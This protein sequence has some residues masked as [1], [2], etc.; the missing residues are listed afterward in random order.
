MSDSTPRDPAAVAWRNPVPPPADARAEAEP[1][2]LGFDGANSMVYIPAAS[3]AQAAM[4]QALAWAERASVWSL[5]GCVNSDIWQEWKA[6][7]RSL[8]PY[9]DH[10]PVPLPIDGHAYRRRTRARTRARARRSRSRRARA[11][12]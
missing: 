9:D 12:R 4:R 1:V 7:V 10:H 2:V 6:F 11:G 3:S 5:A 8:S